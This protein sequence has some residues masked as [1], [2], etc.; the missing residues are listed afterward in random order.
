MKRLLNQDIFYLKNN[1]EDRDL[2]GDS[3][4]DGQR[5]RQLVAPT[6]GRGRWFKWKLEAGRETN[7]YQGEE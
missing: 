7:G 6:D 4:M 2:H 1:M 5:S 3:F